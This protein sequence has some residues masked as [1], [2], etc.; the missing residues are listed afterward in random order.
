[1]QE[2][3]NIEFKESWRD[4]Y[5][6]WICGFAN[7]DGGSLIIGRSDK[8]KSVG[9]K[10][11]RTLMELIPNKVLDI[12]GIMVDVNLN[13]KSGK[14][15]LEIIVNPYPNPISYKGEYYYRSGSTNHALR[16]SALS[17]FLIQKQGLHW[18]SMPVFKIAFEEL[19][20][21]AIKTFKELALLN[22]RLDR[23]ILSEEDTD[24][25]E[26]LHLLEGGY[27]KRAAA[28][29]FHPDPE[30]FVTGAY[31]KIGYF[32][33]D[34][35]LLYQDEVHGNLL[36]QVDRVLEI[37]QAKYFKAIISF[38]GLQR[39]ETYPVPTL[40]L[41]EAILNAIAH[42][43]YASGYPI[44]ISVYADKLMIWNPGELPPKWS[45][46]S[47]FEKH[48]SQPFNPDIASV[49]FRAGMIEA[50][51]SGI[52]RML[53]SCKE[54]GLPLPEFKT[55]DS[56]IWLVF[57][58]SDRYTSAKT[59]RKVID[60]EIVQE[61]DQEIDQEVGS[62]AKKILSLIKNKPTITRR[63]L[64]SQIGV[65]ERVVQYQLSKLKT[66][67]LLVRQGSTKAGYWQLLKP[68]SGANH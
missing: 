30:K 51:G 18:D 38:E 37:L 36:M 34:S 1:M 41:R 49:F 35:R 45:L 8:G 6:K 28:M 47:L 20:K 50:W 54:G 53:E 65:A 27:L 9:L 12:L 14:E 29:L 22:K 67:G 3:Q 40:A 23:R 61:I 43:D 57:L 59:A 62:V 46:E 63:E 5:L 2:N 68:S 11:S 56:G 10:D 58:Y 66:C 17:R 13:R 16:G 60:Q 44:Q 55:V 42:K 25:F 24:L 4:E 52:A 33:S 19:E 64:A 21:S 15:F 39:I 48:S 32:E 26:K 31:I 7:A